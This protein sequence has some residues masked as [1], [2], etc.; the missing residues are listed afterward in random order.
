MP[1]Y[2][3]LMRRASNQ[4]LTNTGDVFS[5]AFWAYKIVAVSV[6][7]RDN[8]GTKRDREFKFCMNTTYTK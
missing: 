6:R 4:S 5:P 2:S 3:Q 7:I 8:S 1:F